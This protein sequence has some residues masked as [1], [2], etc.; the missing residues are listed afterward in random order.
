METRPAMSVEV[1]MAKVEVIGYQSKKTGRKESFTKM[2]VGCEILGTGE[3][4]IVSLPLPEGATKKNTKLPFTKGQAVR[5]ILTDL[6]TR[7]G[8]LTGRASEWS[9]EKDFRGK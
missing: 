6:Q 2:T 1:R 5:F 9:D 7:Q 4:A 3:P 8:V